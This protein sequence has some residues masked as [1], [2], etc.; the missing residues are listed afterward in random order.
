MSLREKLLVEFGGDPT[1][2]MHPNDPLRQQVTDALERLEKIDNPIT[3]LSEL[4]KF[5]GQLTDELER[6]QPMMDAAREWF[7]YNAASIMV[8]AERRKMTAPE[9][10]KNMLDDI[11]DVYK[12]QSDLEI[13]E[14][15]VVN[16]NQDA[17]RG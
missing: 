1:E 8:E 5:L 17:D 10:V 6:R 14:D 11:F 4:F 3:M 2:Q 12:D 7:V 16:R 15:D 13:E 9:F